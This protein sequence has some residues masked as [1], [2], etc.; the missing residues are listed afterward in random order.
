VRA[1]AGAIFVAVALDYTLASTDLK[2]SCSM[3]LMGAGRTWTPSDA[4]I[5]LTIGDVIPGVS[6]DCSST[7]PTGIPTLGGAVGAFFQIPA[8]ALG[9]IQGVQVTVQDVFTWS[10][11]QQASPVFANP[12]ASAV[13]QITIQ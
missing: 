2:Q 3:Q 7:S 1:T 6:A 12:S 4:D 8:A 11:T 10:D 9:E 13:F 5:G